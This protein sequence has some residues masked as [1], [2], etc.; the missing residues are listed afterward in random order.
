MEHDC[1]IKLNIFERRTT[2][3][4]D[5]TK[6][7]ASKRIKYKW[8]RTTSESQVKPCKEYNRED[9]QTFQILKK[10]KHIPFNLLWKRKPIT[11]TDPR[12]KFQLPVSI[13]NLC[14]TVLIQNTFP[15][16]KCNM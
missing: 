4:N 2:Y 3:L 1:E 5:F 16:I 7:P 9:H 13:H 10:D 12:Q 11:R 6:Y 15:F 14:I 8:P